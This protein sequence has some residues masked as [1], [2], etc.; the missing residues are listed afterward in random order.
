MDAIAAHLPAVQRGEA[1]YQ[2][3]RRQR[4]RAS[5]MAAV[6]VAA[7]FLVA[8]RFSEFYP[9]SL[10]AGLPRI[11]EYFQR[12]LPTLHLPVLLAGAGTEGSLAFWFYRLDS[13]LLLLLQTAQMAALATLGGTVVA[14]L[15]AFPAARNLAP[16]RWMHHLTRRGLEA[17]RTV[18]EIVYA[19]IFVWAFG[20]GPLAGILAIGLHTAGALGK[21]FSEVIE[22]APMQAWD[23]MRASG[24]NWAQA[25]RYAI[26]PQVAPDLLSYALLRF[27]INL[28]G[29]TVIGFVGAGGI[30]QEL[31]Q[32]I[33]FNYYEEISAIVV[34]VILSVM[35]IDL[36]S[37][38]LRHRLIHAAGAR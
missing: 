14:L 24:A 22:N 11:G 13:W 7:G 18:P 31:Y 34:L 2:A 27:E 32:V 28:R 5:L 8:A 10:A 1:A 25:C 17:T 12:I 3:L 4:R 21:L 19:L 36:L 9:A 30:G 6:L 29:A 37:E 23:G 20:V 33:A 26:L 38:W 16:S 35:L 15:L